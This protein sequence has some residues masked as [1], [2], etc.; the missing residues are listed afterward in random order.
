MTQFNDS[1][2][3]CINDPLFLDQFY[4]VFLA[5]SDEIRAMFKD[6]DMGTQKAMLMTS[7][8]YMSDAHK[9]TPGLLASIAE[10]H[11]KDHLNIK[12]YFYALWLDSLIAAAK[13]IDP[14]FDVKTE[15]LWKETLQQGIDFMI[16]KYEPC[17]D[18]A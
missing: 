10:K 16:S 3:R 15:M 8:V 7:L 13:S 17:L 12:P 5:S 4:E 2:V 6:T 18:D 9:D 1:F 14:L 11:D